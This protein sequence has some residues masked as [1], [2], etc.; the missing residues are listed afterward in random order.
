MRRLV[1]T[2]FGRRL[3]PWLRLRA[4]GVVVIVVALVGATWWVTDAVTAQALYLG[5]VFMTVAVA[6]PAV[7]DQLLVGASAGVGA[8]VAGSAPLLTARPGGT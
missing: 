3:P 1:S 2:A 6:H 7:R 4:A 5:V 8:L